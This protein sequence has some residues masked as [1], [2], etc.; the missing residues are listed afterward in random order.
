MTAGYDH[1]LRAWDFNALDITAPRSFREIEPWEG[2][3][4]TDVQFSNSGDRV[5]VVS[6][7]PRAKLFS[8][9]CEQL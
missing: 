6:G 7:A 9:E 8:R 1:Y 5:L 2:Y 3:P 4:I